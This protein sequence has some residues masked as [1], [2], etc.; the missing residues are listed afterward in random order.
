MDV[1]TRDT[2]KL[3]YRFKDID[4]YLYIY[5]KNVSGCINNLSE[6]MN[7]ITFRRKALKKKKKDK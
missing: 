4:L 3:F 5:N 1:L 7:S 6:H 2:N